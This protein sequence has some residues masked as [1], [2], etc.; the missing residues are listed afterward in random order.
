MPRPLVDLF[1]FDIAGT[2]VKDDNVVQRAFDRV[3]DRSKLT[4]PSGWIRERMGWN[5]VQVF[6]EALS[7][8]GR[9]TGPAGELAT[10]FTGEIISMMDESPPV[11]LP[12]A[13]EALRKLR[14][15][16]VMIAFNTGY[17][18]ALAS[19]IIHRMGWAPD[20]I[21]G[22]DLV[23]HGRPAPDMIHLAMERTGVTDVGRV[24]VIGDTPSDL[25]AGT[26]AGCRFVI[27]VGHGTF[28][29][30]ELGGSPHTHLVPD[31]ESLPEILNVLV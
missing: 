13:A 4:V 7:M 8:N 14:A 18:A 27:G 12:G 9:D 10:E 29:L 23:A 3:I 17:S 31:L 15:A 26:A 22:S 16:G 1:V 5:K 28:T 11:A 25:K 30:A 19:E 20:A 6:A 24:G 21:V 2:T